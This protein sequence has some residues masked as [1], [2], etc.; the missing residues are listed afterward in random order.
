MINIALV[1]GGAVLLG[2]AVI[3]CLSLDKKI[4]RNIIGPACYIV[5]GLICFFLAGY[6]FFFVRLL[7]LYP[8]HTANELL[9]SLVFFFGAVFVVVILNV[10]KKL[11]L[12]INEKNTRLEDANKQ[13]TI[14]TKEAESSREKY[15]EKSEELERTLEDYYTARV[16]AAEQVAKGT[17]GQISEKLRERLDKLKRESAS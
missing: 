1:V 16:D 14:K 9:I 6:I 15:R 2:Y 13:L 5:I 11:L 17:F 4:E 8:L 3:V 12:S 10:N 7:E